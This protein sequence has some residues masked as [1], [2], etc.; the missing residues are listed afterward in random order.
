MGY[1]R[2]ALLMAAMPQ[3]E[4]QMLVPDRR[5]FM[6]LLVFAVLL[7]ALPIALMLVALRTI[8]VF[9]QQ[10]VVNLEPVYAVLLAIPILGEQQELNPLF[11]LGVVVI[12]GAVMTEPLLQWLRRRTAAHRPSS[13]L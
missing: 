2:T 12:V 13:A 4:L 8:T 1:L 7:T 9:A 3:V 5:D 6:L 10:M 11:Y